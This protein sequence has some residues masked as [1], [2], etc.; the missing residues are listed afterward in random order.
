MQRPIFLALTLFA[1]PAHWLAAQQ[2]NAGYEGTSTPPSEDVVVTTTQVFEPPPHAAVA[3]GPSLANDESTSLGYDAAH[4][5]E[6][7]GSYNGQP[8][9]SGSRGN[10]YTYQA[11]RQSSGSSYNTAQYSTPQQV[12]DPY[13][14]DQY[15]SQQYN[16][17]A[18][19]Q[20]YSTPRAT[21]QQRPAYGSSGTGYNATVY[22]DPDGDIVIEKDGA[23]MPARRPATTAPRSQQPYS[24]NTSQ[25]YAAS[26]PYP[27]QNYTQPYPAQQ[28]RYA[29]PTLRKR[30][31][32]Y[33]PDGDIVHPHQRKPG[34]LGVGATIR[35]RLLGRLSSAT[36]EKGERFRSRVSRDVYDEGL[37]VIPA[38]S[39]LDGRVVQASRGHLGGHG[40][41]RLR[42]D[43]LLLP[44]GTRYHLYADLTDTPGTHTRVGSEGAVQPKSRAGKN[45]AEFAGVVGAGAATGA[46]V[47]GAGGAIAGTLV[48]AGV[49]TAHLLVD[50]P[51]ATL[52]SGSQMQFTLTEPLNLVIEAGEK[53]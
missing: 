37:L 4:A 42:P 38:G 8:V 7:S 52:E 40:T 49:V 6:D 35:V 43:S 2:G 17:P 45:T 23:P 24:R 34:E 21:S 39:E 9:S 31:I 46:I 29:E 30:E 50:H 19:G 18:Q 10:S 14:T 11:P 12:S 27:A 26:Q 51:Q 16:Q 44:D 22:E 13:A 25:P 41:L 28:Q 1:L 15:G 20:Q 48:G 32:P 33:D 3:P 5:S 53:Y 36:S 47:G